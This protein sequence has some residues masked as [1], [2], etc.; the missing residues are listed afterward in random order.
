MAFSAQPC[1]GQV[2]MSTGQLSRNVRS[3]PPQ[4]SWQQSSL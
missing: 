1:L 3:G 2:Q 4:L